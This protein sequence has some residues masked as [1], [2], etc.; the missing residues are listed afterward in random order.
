[1]ALNS[2]YMETFKS[3]NVNVL[4]MYDEIDQFLSMNIQVF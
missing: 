2:P 4:L 1:M 3:K